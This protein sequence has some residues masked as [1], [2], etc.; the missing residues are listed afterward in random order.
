MIASPNIIAKPAPQIPKITPDIAN[1]STIMQNV[2]I[3][4]N[5]LY[6]FLIKE[7]VFLAKSLRD[8][9]HF[10]LRPLSFSSY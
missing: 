5:L 7:C 1:I 3:I 10:D 9:D 2:I 6:K 8:F 4:D